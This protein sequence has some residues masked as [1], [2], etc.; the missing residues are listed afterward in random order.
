M[1]NIV[2][3]K[4]YPYQLCCSESNIYKSMTFTNLSLFGNYYET[5]I[6]ETQKN[7]IIF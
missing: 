3:I 1:F 7:I 6:R 5:I 4:I 2:Y